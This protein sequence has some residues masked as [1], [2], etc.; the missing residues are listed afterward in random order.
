MLKE[1]FMALSLVT[2]CGRAPSKPNVD[3]TEAA[4][5]TLVAQETATTQRIEDMLNPTPDQS[6]MPCSLGQ[7]LAWR[8]ILIPPMPL[9]IGDVK[10]E[11]NGDLVSTNAEGFGPWT[12]KF[13]DPVQL[14]PFKGLCFIESGNNIV[15]VEGSKDLPQPTNAVKVP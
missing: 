1:A 10:F 8:Y 15:M 13:G 11:I 9:Q 3:A 12:L 7:D 2:A 6:T 5:G 4:R 14:G